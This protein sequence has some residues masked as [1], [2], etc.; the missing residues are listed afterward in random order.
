MNQKEAKDLLKELQEASVP[1]EDMKELTKMVF[2]GF[3]KMLEDNAEK[4]RDTSLYLFLLTS[5][6]QNITLREA[7]ERYMIQR[8][9]VE[10]A[11]KPTL[12]QRL[13]WEY[14]IRIVERDE[15]IDIPTELWN[16]HVLDFFARLGK[17]MEIEV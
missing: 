1:T 13:E 15:S 2:D 17:K 12:M 5:V 16:E 3:D 6:M 9:N 10:P 8:E 7:Y 11:I 14:R 4:E